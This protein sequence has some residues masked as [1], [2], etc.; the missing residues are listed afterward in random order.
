MLGDAL[1]PVEK[2]I[3]DLQESIGDV[4][5]ESL[6]AKWAGVMKGIV[7]GDKAELEDD[8]K[9]LFT[10]SGIVH[11]L[12][13]SGLHVSVLGRGFYQFLRKRGLGFLFSGIAATIVLL[14]YGYLTGNGISTLRAI[15]MMLLFM[16]AQL[17]GRS[18]DM[19]NALGGVC[20]FLLWENP[21]LVEPW[22]YTYVA[23]CGCIL[24]F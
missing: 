22:D 11:I 14:G 20:L 16:L 6:P 18:Y 8:I 9:T 19:L 17:S 4:Y 23:S 2:W 10:A 12:T 13:V 21:F 24:L 3:L 15:G 5:E 7:L 1:N